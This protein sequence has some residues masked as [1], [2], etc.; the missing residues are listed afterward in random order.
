[1]SKK[2]NNDN[3]IIYIIVGA[4][5]MYVLFT[6]GYIGG[7]GAVAQPTPTP[8][9]GLMTPTPVPGTSPVATPTYVPTTT[10]TSTPTPLPEGYMTNAECNTYC[11]GQPYHDTFFMHG[12]WSDYTFCESTALTYCSIEQ[13]VGVCV[14]QFSPMIGGI[15]PPGCCCW[16]CEGEQYI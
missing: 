4:L 11:N 7:T 16:L 6:S 5:A 8:T 10:P 1:M 2:K 14:S 15:N 12:V 3:A 13:E 9:P